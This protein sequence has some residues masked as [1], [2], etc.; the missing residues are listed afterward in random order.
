MNERLFI[1]CGVPRSGTTIIARFIGGLPCVNVRHE[2]LQSIA[3][4]S[5]AGAVWRI[6]QIGE[7]ISDQSLYFGFKEVFHHVPGFGQYA[8]GEA[9]ALLKLAGV[10][11]VWINR[12]P[13]ATFNSQKNTWGGVIFQDVKRFVQNWNAFQTLRFGS[14][15]IDYDKFCQDPVAEWRR[16][17]PLP[18]DV[19][20]HGMHLAYCDTPDSMGCHKAKTSAAI[21]KDETPNTVTDEEAKYIRGYA[22]MD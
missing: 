21:E 16:V 3:K 12:D 20:E 19:D 2:P 14:P 18:V 22:I 11:F 10:R 7:L 1:I 15:V 4:Q 13:V 17:K 8:N 9:L 6:V 5:E